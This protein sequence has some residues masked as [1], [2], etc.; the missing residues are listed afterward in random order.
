[1][2][3][4]IANMTSEFDDDVVSIQTEVSGDP[5]SGIYTK[6][7]TKEGPGF[8][9]IAKISISAMDKGE[10]DEGFSAVLNSPARSQLNQLAQEND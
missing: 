7:V 3:S 10:S 8:K 9:A 4:L 6:S 5:Y 2:D 1:M